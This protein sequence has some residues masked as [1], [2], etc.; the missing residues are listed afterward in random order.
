MNVV[1]RSRP[2]VK[3]HP[4]HN[5]VIN[6]TVKTR[7]LLSAHWK[8]GGNGFIAGE[9]EGIV[10]VGGEPAASTCSPARPWNWSMRNG[11]GTTAHTALPA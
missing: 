9:G 6:L 3:T 11:A 4:R 10:T 1:I 8:Y 5:R 7:P 2:R